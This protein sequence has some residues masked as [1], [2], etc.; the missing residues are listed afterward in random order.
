VADLSPGSRREGE[1]GQLLLI[2][3]FIIAVSFVVLAL[4]VNSAIFTENL[5]TRDEVAGSGDALEYRQEVTQSGGD[6]LTEINQNN[7]ID[8]SDQDDK[9]EENLGY[10]NTQ[11]G[12]QQS[13]QGRIVEVENGSVVIETGIK[14]AQDTS[15]PFSNTSA[16]SDFPAVVTDWVVVEDVETTRNL[17]M[18][19]TDLDELASPSDPRP[20]ELEIENSSASWGMTI[21]YEDTTDLVTVTVE[22]PTHGSPELCTRTATDFIEI[23]VTRGTVG[24][25]PCHALSQTT[26]GT[27]MWFGLE[28]EY[29]IKFNNYDSIEGTYSFIIDDGDFD[30][31]NFGDGGSNPDDY[32]YDPYYRDAIYN[33]TVPFN[34]HTADVGYE[35]EIEIAPGEVPP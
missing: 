12:L 31:D 25:E 8:T 5:A 3:A 10:I 1:R 14:V 22:S 35:T 4:V 27:P 9:L 28:G 21:I 7:S 34:Y 18:N 30:D 20:F 19:I 23:D 11:G 13:A 26:D 24:G 6:V 17:R 15:R 32:S 29:D 2:G 16:T 33:A